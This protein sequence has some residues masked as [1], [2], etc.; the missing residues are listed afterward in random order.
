MKRWMIFA[1]LGLLV[2]LAAVGL[3]FYH[4]QAQALGP[5]QDHGLPADVQRALGHA[6][7]SL[8]VPGIQVPVTWHVISAQLATNPDRL[9]VKGS[10]ANAS[11]VWCT[12]IAPAIT[13]QGTPSDPAITLDHFVVA[14]VNNQWIAYSVDGLAASDAQGVY[15]SLGCTNG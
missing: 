7:D 11:H 1:Q 15:I 12:R 5:V 9:S 3:L 2:L 8:R 14:Q 10:T 4:N 6:V 13:T